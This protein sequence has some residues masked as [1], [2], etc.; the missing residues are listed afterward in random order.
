MWVYFDVD[1]PTMLQ[2]HELVRQGKFGPA[3]EGQ[4]PKIPFHL[5]L[6]NEKGFPHEAILDFVNNE[7]NQATATLLV[8]AVFPNPL[9][10][11]GPRVFIPTNFVRFRVPTSG[12]YQALLVSPEAIGTDQDLKYVFVVDDDN[13]VVRR[14]VKLG[15]LQ[16]G[17]QAVTEGI[18]PGE[19]VIVNGLHASQPAPSLRR[20]SCRCRFS[21]GWIQTP[22]LTTPAPRAKK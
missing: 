10:A 1:E 5:Q 21:R 8:R 11:N 18:K 6:A 12:P 17:L 14:A 19:R 20:A 9:P 13:K 16:D 22:V 2:V 15:S 7:V 3:K 4:P